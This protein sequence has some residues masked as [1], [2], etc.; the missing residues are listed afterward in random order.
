M[1]KSRSLVSFC[2]RNTAAMALSLAFGGAAI[3]SQA[4][5]IVPACD[6]SGSGTF[7]C[8]VIVLHASPKD[9]SD[10]SDIAT[11]SGS[12]VQFAYHRIRA[13]AATVP[14]A[15]VLLLLRRH[16]GIA[17]I[18]DRRVD[19]I[20]PV[21]VDATSG[22][23]AAAAAQ[24]VP[25]G[26]AHIGAAPGVLPVN[27]SGV[28]VAI[29]DTGIDFGHED[30]AP[31]N[32]CYDAY[33]SDCTDQNGHGTHVTGIIA[34]LDNTVDVVGVAPGATPYA[35]RVLNRFGSG[36]DS[37]ILAG[38]DWIIQNADSVT[39]PIRVVNM[40][41][42]RPGT[43]NDD[44]A[45]RSA[46]QTLTQ[47][48]GI[49]VVVAAGNDPTAE[50]SSQVPAGY[51]EVF[52]VASTTAM[53]SINKC[54]SNPQFMPADTASSY[55]TDGMYDPI[56]GI[57]VTISAPG[58]R[59]EIVTSSC[60]LF[61]NGILSTKLGGG[62]TRLAGTSMAAPHV[63]GVVALLLQAA[64]GPVD[65]E[66]I[67]SELRATASRVGLAPF[68]SPSPD[69]SFDGEREGV[70]SACGALGVTCP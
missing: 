17:V 52:A 19:A 68:N 41:L 43:L 57:G 8:G 12:T 27:G 56:T 30:L 40:S 39:P 1:S 22:G 62:T 25:A 47:T 65:P 7:P 5:G 35:V 69:Y 60:Y 3:A 53:Y 24:V 21:S 9:Q 31:S 48:L 70:V 55:T 20:G 64:G 49:A 23:A 36:T 67:R 16:A 26:V 10:L 32:A 29:V 18:P 45:F 13:A 37:K 33:G 59:L 28:G 2:I 6:L 15:K 58:E 44:P 34:A 51:P 42:G 66:T 50:V 63:A 11:Q 61:N 54:A 46:I 38:L 4:D 14:N